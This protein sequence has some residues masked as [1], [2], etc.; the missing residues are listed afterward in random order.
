MISTLFNKTKRSILVTHMYSDKEN[1]VKFWYEA[2][3]VG[4]RYRVTHFLQ[5]AGSLKMTAA[6]DHNVTKKEAEKFMDGIEAVSKEF[7]LDCGIKQETQFTPTT[8]KDAES[9]KRR[10]FKAHKPVV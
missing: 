6:F 9:R 2:Y 7:M 5:N 3:P 1:T 10:H 8:L 4:N